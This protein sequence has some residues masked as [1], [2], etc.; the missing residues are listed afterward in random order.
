MPDGDDPALNKP[1]ETVQ[2]TNA[3]TSKVV[4]ATAGSAF[5]G[6]IGVLINYL[7]GVGTGHDLPKEVQAAI[8]TAITTLITFWSAWATPHAAGERV[9]QLANGSV[10]AAKLVP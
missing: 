6:A 1:A 9:V 10:R 5:A 2:P 7:I 8:I 4:A 3:P